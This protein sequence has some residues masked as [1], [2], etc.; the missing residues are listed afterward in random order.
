VYF[1]YNPGDDDEEYYKSQ[2]KSIDDTYRNKIASGAYSEVYA[3]GDD[4]SSF[5]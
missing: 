3:T 5:L 1:S 4:L 2:A